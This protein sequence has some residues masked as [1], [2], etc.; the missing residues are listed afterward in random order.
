MAKSAKQITQFVKQVFKMYALDY[1]G[2]FCD[3]DDYGEYIPAQIF[4]NDIVDEKSIKE[5]SVILGI[6]IDDILNT[7]IEAAKKWYKKYSFFS[8]VPKIIGAMKRAEY[9]SKGFNEVHLLKAVFGE[10]CASE[11]PLRYNKVSVKNRLIEKLK[12]I[13][14]YIPN[15][16]H[17]GADIENL[18]IITQQFYSYPQIA[19]MAL[20]FFEMFERMKYLFY[21]AKDNSVFTLKQDEIDEYNFLVSVF[22]VRDKASTADLYYDNI[23]K[24]RKVYKQE[25][26]KDFFSYVRIS[27]V[28]GFATPWM[29]KEFTERKELFQMYVNIYPEQLPKIRAAAMHIS[30]F[31][32]VF[33]WSDAQPVDINSDDDFLNLNDDDLLKTAKQMQD[34]HRTVYIDKTADELDGDDKF[35]ERLTYLIG[36]PSMGGITMPKRELPLNLRYDVSL[37]EFQDRILAHSQALRSENND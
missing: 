31:E 8:H 27:P 3:F 29:C 13:N 7:N 21:R 33:N 25:E 14:L 30:K 19:T 10:K 15:T 34:Y 26:Y 35:A 22:G 20:S 1:E 11:Y 23:V 32:C 18:Q 24:L 16:F 2:F 36:V 4:R 37:P 28:L 17:E 9:S 6:S 12:D 5:I